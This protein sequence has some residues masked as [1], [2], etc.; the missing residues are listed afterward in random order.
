MKLGA[1]PRHALER[2]DDVIRLIRTMDLTQEQWAEAQHA[3]KQ[4]DVALKSG[5]ELALPNACGRLEDMI[6][7]A[8]RGFVKVWKDESL[9]GKKVR[10]PDE[11]YYLLNEMQHSI[12]HSLDEFD[13]SIEPASSAPND[14]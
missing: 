4:L 6:P 10:A 9:K 1:I 12:V 11:I 3:L 8:V 7:P 14:N 13:S 2:A 5:D